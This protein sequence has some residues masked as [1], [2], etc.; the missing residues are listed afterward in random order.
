VPRFRA[1]SDYEVI[2]RSPLRL[3]CGDVVRPGAHDPAWPGW[4][5]V[6]TESGRMTYLPDA[7]L[8]ADADGIYRVG[9]EFDA[10]DLSLERGQLV[11]V[12]REVGGWFWCRAENGAEGWAPD[13]LLDPF[14]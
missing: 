11:E 4:T 9:A 10:T 2:D 1:N 5:L 6:A 12:L 3:A 7:M 8:E 13:Y 14:D